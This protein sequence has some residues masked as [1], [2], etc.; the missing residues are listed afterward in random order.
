[1]T[2]PNRTR[3]GALMFIGTAWFL[4][5][6]IVSEA[7]FPGYQVTRMISDLGVG[8]TATIYNSAIFG[9]GLLLV[10]AAYLL[11][12]AGINR[13]FLLLLVLTGLGSAGVGIFPENIVVPHSI[14]AITV[15]V[16]GGLCAILGY[17]VFR[18]PWSWFSPIPGVITLIAVVLPGANIY[19]G[20]GAGGMERIIAYPLIIRAIG[21][22]AYLMASE[23]NGT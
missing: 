18:A 22:G 17:R 1:M 19:P 12:T 23:S 20:P 15:F 6:I 3:A 8:S 4:M 11:H 10:A 5:E 13:W 14:C 9:F 21:T 7:L 2:Y 16:C